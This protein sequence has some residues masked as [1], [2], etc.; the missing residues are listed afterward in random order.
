MFT[1]RWLAS[2]ECGCG[3]D[4]PR[5]WKIKLCLGIKGT[6]PEVTMLSEIRKW[7][8]IRERGFSL[9]WKNKSK[10]GKKIAW[11]SQ[12]QSWDQRGKGVE[13]QWCGKA[14]NFGDCIGTYI[15]LEV[16]LGS[17]SEILEKSV[18]N[19]LRGVVSFKWEA[20]ALHMIIWCGSPA[21]HVPSPQHN[22]VQL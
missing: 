9:V 17:V 19:Q 13:D 2:D 8:T 22:Q 20:H 11:L 6:N 10:M 12:N 18:M 14:L 16:L 15:H 21:L 7:E 1:T 4:G 5:V 3:I